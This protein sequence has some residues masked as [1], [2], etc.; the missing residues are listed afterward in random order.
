MVFLHYFIKKI[1]KSVK[2]KKI[3][4]ISIRNFTYLHNNR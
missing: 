3:I 4:P 2:L 1:K